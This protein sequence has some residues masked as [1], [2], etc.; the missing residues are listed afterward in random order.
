MNL[1]DASALLCFLRGEQGA[2]IVERELVVHGVC[3]A[4]NMSETAQEILAHDRD[5]DLAGG[6]LSATV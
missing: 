4:A 6:L 3:S 5:W 1:F 2:D